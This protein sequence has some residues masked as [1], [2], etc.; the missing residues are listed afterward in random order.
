M[1][2]SRV[3]EINEHSAMPAVEGLNGARHVH[4]PGL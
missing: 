2:S 3:L 4:T 1:L